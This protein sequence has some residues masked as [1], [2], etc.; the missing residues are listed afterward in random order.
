[1]TNADLDRARKA[2]EI[3]RTSPGID[4]HELSLKLG[5]GFNITLST[6][7]TMANNDMLVSEDGRGG[8]HVFDIRPVKND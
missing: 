5:I 3:I 2:Y 1:M 7:T 6:L 8:L 4:T